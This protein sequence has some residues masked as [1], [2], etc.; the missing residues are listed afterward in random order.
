MLDTLIANVMNI[1]LKSSAVQSINPGYAI[2]LKST[3]ALLVIAPLVI[4]YVFVQKYFVESIEHSGL[5]G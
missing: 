5:V 4:L 1:I 3:G 2:L